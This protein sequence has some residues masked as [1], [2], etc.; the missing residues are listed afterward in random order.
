MSHGLI[1]LMIDV[2]FPL[3]GEKSIGFI[4]LFLFLQDVIVWAVTHEIRSW[5]LPEKRKLEAL[6]AMLLQPE[7]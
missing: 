2:P 3:D 7:I 4:L 1:S 5:Y 6:R